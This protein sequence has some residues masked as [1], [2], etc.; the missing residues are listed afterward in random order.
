MFAPCMCKE[1]KSSPTDDSLTTTICVL[2][3]ITNV[4]N[5]VSLWLAPFDWTLLATV[6]KAQSEL[7]Y[8]LIAETL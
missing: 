5:V 2:L 3:I 1:I 7:L 8:S 4:A 6:A